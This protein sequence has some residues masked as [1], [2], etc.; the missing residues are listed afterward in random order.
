MRDPYSL[1]AEHGVLGA[2]LIKPELIDMLS[3]DL[4]EADFYWEDNRETYRAILSLRAEN[5]AVDYLTVA[6]RMGANMAYTAELHRNTPSAANADEYARIVKARSLDRALIAAAQTIHEIAHSDAGTEDKV[7]AS[8]AEVLAIDGTA[9][10]QEIIHAGDVMRAHIQELE[11]REELK[12]AMDGLSTGL[13]DLDAKVNGL[14]P[15][16]LIVIAGRAKMGKTTF[17]MGIARHNAIRA[18][19]QVLVI[20]LEMSNGQIM[21]R[22]IAAEGEVPLGALKDGS[23]TT[24]YALEVTAAAGKII[25][26]GMCLSERPGLTISRIR[27]M[28]RRHKMVRGLDLLIIDHLG[29]VD[30]EDSSMNTLA[31]VSEITRQSKL[32]ARELKIPVILLSQLNRALEQRADRRP[33]P[34]DLRDSGTIEQDADLVFFVYRDE[35]YD[36]NTAHKGI[37]EIIVGIARDVEQCTVFTAYQ[38]QYNR[39]VN[40]APGHHIPELRTEKKQRGVSF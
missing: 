15:E 26:S 6:E 28:A 38:G 19:K 25:N 10:C 37:A 30:A 5:K 33:M 13:A 18:K 34:S 7:S 32:L 21:D 8:Q 20:S 39:F 12:G 24:K 16:Q 22:L 27:S 4:A 40:L 29:L 2:M 36:P 35:V 11:R 23:A 31:R 14:K 1:E 3:A 9:A 17:A